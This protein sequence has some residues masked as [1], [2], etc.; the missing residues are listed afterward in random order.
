MNNYHWYLKQ[1][2]QCQL[3]DKITSVAWDVEKALRL[4]YTTTSKN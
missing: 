3:G 1:E 2:I 4:H